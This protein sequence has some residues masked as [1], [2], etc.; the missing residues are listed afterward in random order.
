MLKACEISAIAKRRDGKWRYWCKVHRADATGKGGIPLASCSKHADMP[1]AT[2]DIL[3][4]NPLDY[5]GGIALWGAVPAVYS[6]TVHD[7]D[8]LGVHVHA[9][10]QPKKKKFIDQTYKRVIAQLTGPDGSKRN[11]EVRA[12]DAIAYMVSSI[13]GCEMQYVVCSHCGEPHLDKDYFSV[14]RHQ[15]HLCYGCG[16]N[17]RAERAS[18]GNPLMALKQFCGDEQINRKTVPANRPLEVE[19]AQFPMGIELWGSH[20]AILWTSSAHEE[21]GIHFHGYASN[22]MHPTF[23]ETYDQVTIDGIRLDSDQLRILMAQQVLP[24]L[25]GRIVSLTCP[26]CDGPHFDVGALAYTAHAE[27]TCTCGAVFASPG[28]LKNVVSNP[29]FATLGRLEQKAVRKRR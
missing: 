23:D 14:V 4:L 16:K 9:R 24:H 8:D 1:T 28:R 5:R 10:H 19:Q 2:K 25:Q 15:T 18:V 11:I 6:T 26:T 20:E 3:E 7:M 27:H 12:D 29:M 17:F 13:F 22:F 21:S